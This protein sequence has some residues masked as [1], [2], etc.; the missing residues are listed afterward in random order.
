M[1]WASSS[2]GSRSAAQGGEAVQQGVGGIRDQRRTQAAN[3]MTLADADDM[4]DIVDSQGRRIET[5]AVAAVDLQIEQSRSDPWGDKVCRISNT[6]I[7]LGDAPI[8][9]SQ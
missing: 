4:A 3:A 2:I 9:D 1:A 6:L 5:A 7:Q 8:L